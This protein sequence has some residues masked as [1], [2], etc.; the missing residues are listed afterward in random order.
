MLTEK[1][2][3]YDQALHDPKRQVADTTRENLQWQLPSNVFIRF[4]AGPKELRNGWFGW[5]LRVIAWITL[6]IA[7]VCCSC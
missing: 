1:A 4:L 3:R 5:A 6:V 2:K 7:P